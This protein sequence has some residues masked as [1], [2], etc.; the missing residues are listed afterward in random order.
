MVLVAPLLSEGRFRVGADR[1]GWAPTVSVAPT[2]SGA[3]IVSEGANGFGGASDGKGVSAAPSSPSFSSN[4]SN[5]L[6]S[7]TRKYRFGFQR[8]WKDGMERENLVGDRGGLGG[9]TLPKKKRS[10]SEKR[11]VSPPKKD[12]LSPKRNGLGG[13]SPPKRNPLRSSPLPKNGLGGATPPPSPPSPHSPHNPNQKKGLKP[14]RGG[15]TMCGRVFSGVN[16]S[17]GEGCWAG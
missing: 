13:A 7:K 11:I 9:A 3:P 12:G 17:G 15:E 5:P 14:T 1:F 2:V 4:K 16:A 6:P 10:P 8:K